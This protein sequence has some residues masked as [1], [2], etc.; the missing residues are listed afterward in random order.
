MYDDENYYLKAFDATEKK[1]K[2]YRVD[3]MQEITVIEKND[4]VL[5]HLRI[6]IRLSIPRSYLECMTEKKKW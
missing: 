4:K 2:T 1:L 3:K 6:K 5:L